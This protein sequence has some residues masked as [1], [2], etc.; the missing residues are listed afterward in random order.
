MRQL[1]SLL[2]LL[3][4][5]ASAYAQPPKK[6]E[7][8]K[9]VDEAIKKALKFLASTQNADGSW[10]SGRGS[11]PAIS[12]LTVMAFLSAGHVPGEGPYGKNVEKGVRAVLKMQHPNGLFSANGQW[13]MYN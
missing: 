4:L 5:V 2:C 13:E 10:S 1:I 11:E 3:C 6:D 9:K 8:A 7:N 12:A